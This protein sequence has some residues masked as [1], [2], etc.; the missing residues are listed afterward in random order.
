MKKF[1]KTKYDQGSEQRTEVETKYKTI[2][3]FENFKQTIENKFKDMDWKFYA[4]IL[5]LIFML[6]AI[7]VSTIYFQIEISRSNSQ[8]EMFLFDNY[9]K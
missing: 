4:I 2:P 8:I 3:D 1:I 7:I 6:G 9:K 5:F